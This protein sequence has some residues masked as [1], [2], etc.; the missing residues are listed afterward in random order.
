VLTVALSDIVVEIAAGPAAFCSQ[1]ALITGDTDL[2]L[3]LAEVALF[4]STPAASQVAL[5]WYTD[6][7]KLHQ[8]TLNFEISGV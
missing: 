3:V 4:F 1:V 5:S 7:I 2:A 8:S 6:L